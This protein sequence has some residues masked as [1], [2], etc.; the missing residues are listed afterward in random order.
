MTISIWRYS[1]L[2]LAIS[3]ALFIVIASLTGVIL[4]FEPISNKIKPYASENLNTISIS[5]TIGVLQEKYDEVI[6]IEIDENDF[7]SASIINKE[8]ENKTFYINPK[9]GENIGGIIKKSALFEFATNLHRSLFLKTT[10]RFIIA[11][12]SLLLLLI[13]ITGT[14]LIARRQ[15]GFSKIFTNIVKED[16]NQY[17]H[18]FY[19]RYFLIP[20]IIIT[21]SG[22]YLSLDKFSL[23]PKK[24]HK[25]EKLEIDKVASNLKVTNFD[26]FKS[27][28]LNEIQNIEFPFSK[29]EEDYFQVKTLNNEFSI[30]QFNGQIIKKKKQD[31][32]T[33]GSYYSLIFHTGKGS[34][35]WSLILF[36]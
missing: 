32:V 20:I 33:L 30:H 5:E 34:I 2:T 31:L 23:L 26:F 1:H 10:G 21:L 9:T 4:A 24:N 13:S 25:Y 7:V 14:I 28:K 36:L 15:G 18:I 3:S 6:T 22:I 35:I 12:V 29:D 11:A 8:G 16:F 27:K 17:Y 19:G